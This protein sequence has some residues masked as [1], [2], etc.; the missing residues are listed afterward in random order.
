MSAVRVRY[1]EIQMVRFKVGNMRCGGCARAVTAA[2][3]GVDPKAEVHVDLARREISV[4]SCT[5]DD[6]LSHALRNAGFEEQ[7]LAA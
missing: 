5:S 1:R 6:R 4:E 7:R 3:R 2:L